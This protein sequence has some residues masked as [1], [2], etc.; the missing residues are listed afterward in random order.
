VVVGDHDCGERSFIRCAGGE[1]E[2][3]DLS[4]VQFRAHLSSPRASSNGTDEH[5]F[6]SQ[7]S[8][9][10]S[11]IQRRASRR[12]L[13]VFSIVLSILV[14]KAWKPVENIQGASADKEDAGRVHRLCPQHIEIA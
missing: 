10:E 1:V 6:A 2:E 3:S 9:S 12:C 14:G 7:Q 11:G 4:T 8:M 13:E 5:R